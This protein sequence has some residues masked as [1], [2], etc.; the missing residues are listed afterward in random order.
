[1]V[2]DGSL[3]CYPILAALA[4]SPPGKSGAQRRKTSFRVRARG[5][6]SR[7]DGTW[8]IFGGWHG[9]RAAGAGPAKLG[10]ELPGASHTLAAASTGEADFLIFDFPWADG[11]VRQGSR[12]VDR[13]VT[14]RL[15]TTL[16]V[17]CC[18]DRGRLVC[19]RKVG[20]SLTG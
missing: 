3:Q 2:V 13:L 7:Q 12:A 1:M 16:N 6:P 11:W 4:A 8:G 20:W 15:Q 17:S 5:S 14:R 10:E 9:G 19:A 18:P